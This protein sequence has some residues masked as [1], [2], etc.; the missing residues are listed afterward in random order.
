MTLYDI[1]RRAIV[2]HIE[3]NGLVNDEKLATE[4]TIAVSRYQIIQKIGTEE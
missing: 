4:I 3:K 2:A 1:I